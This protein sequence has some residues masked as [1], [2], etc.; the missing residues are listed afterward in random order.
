MGNGFPDDRAYKMY[1]ES[2][3]DLPNTKTGGTGLGL[4]IAK[5]FTEAQKGSIKIEN[6]MEG[7][8]KVSF[9][10]PTDVSFVNQLKN[11]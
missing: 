9:S 3:T 10:I 7:G 2:F 11:E 4:S 1:L 5:G 6:R 8:A